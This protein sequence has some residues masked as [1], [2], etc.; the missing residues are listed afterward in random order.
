MSMQRCP[1][2]CDPHSCT[3]THDAFLVQLLNI[4]DSNLE[5]HYERYQLTKFMR[6][7]EQVITVFKIIQNLFIGFTNMVHKCNYHTSDAVGS[8]NC[9]QT[10]TTDALNLSSFFLFHFPSKLAHVSAT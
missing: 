8:G 3:V 10:P 6:M 7:F 1:P 5:T 9:R 2:F 4:K